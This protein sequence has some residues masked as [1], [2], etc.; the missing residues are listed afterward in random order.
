[1][2]EIFVLTQVPGSIAYC[3]GKHAMEGMMKALASEVAKL[4][5]RINN[6]K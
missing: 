3:A 4:G 1:M 6:A 5:V 2:V